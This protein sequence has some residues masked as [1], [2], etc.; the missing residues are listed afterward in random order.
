M[1]H[2]IQKKHYP[3][4][5]ASILGAV[6]LLGFVGIGALWL[7]IGVW[8]GMVIQPLICIGIGCLISLGLGITSIVQYT[9]FFRNNKNGCQ[10]NASVIGLVFG[11]LVSLKSL[12][13][14]LGLTGSFLLPF[15]FRNR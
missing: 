11:I 6:A 12:F 5:M 2:Y 14:L 1:V 3:G 15:I 9:R 13:I 4:V 7:F 10:S 8:G